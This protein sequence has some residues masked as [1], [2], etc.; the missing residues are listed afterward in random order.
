MRK[1]ITK[2]ANF[3]KRL[4]DISDC[5]EAGAVSFEGQGRDKYGK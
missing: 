1:I 5:V 2:I 3:F 4:F